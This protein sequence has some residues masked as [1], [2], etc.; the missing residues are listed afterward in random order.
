M[1]MFSYCFN[2]KAT[3]APGEQ[4]TLRSEPSRLA[5]FKPERLLVSD[6]SA[7]HDKVPVSQVIHCIRELRFPH[8]GDLRIDGGLYPKDDG[9]SAT[10]LVNVPVEKGGVIEVDV[11]LPKS[12]KFF[13]AIFGVGRE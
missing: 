4:M 10:I 2:L 1:K 12:G 6:G 7:D 9:T 8:V 3:G 11:V 13:A 5:L